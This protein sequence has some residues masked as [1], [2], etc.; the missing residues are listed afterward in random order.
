MEL[1]S[2][3]STDSVSFVMSK[4]GAFTGWEADSVPVEVWETSSIV[5][6]KDGAATAEVADSGFS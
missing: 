1:S 6:L 2:V 5:M 4:E 3:M